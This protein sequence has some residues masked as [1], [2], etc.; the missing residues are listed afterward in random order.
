MSVWQAGQGKAI[1]V[2]GRGLPL[3]LWKRRSKEEKK[4]QSSWKWTNIWSWVPTGLDTTTNRAGWLLLTSRGGPQFCEKSR[5]TH[6]LDNRLTD[7]SE[8][9]RR[10]APFTPRKIAGTHFCQRLS[11]PQGHSVAGR[12]RSVEKSSDLKCGG[13]GGQICYIGLKDDSEGVCQILWIP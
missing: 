12:I 1:L 8:V 5:L 6:F 13:Q 11:R 4:K 2:T 10:T 9:V 3:I 7:G